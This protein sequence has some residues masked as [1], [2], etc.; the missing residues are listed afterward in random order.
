MYYCVPPAYLFRAPLFLPDG[1]S[2]A[3]FASHW[4]IWG[5]LAIA[6]GGCI[7]KG[8]SSGTRIPLKAGAAM[9][10]ITALWVLV[11]WAVATPRER[12]ADAHASLLRAAETSDPDAVLRYLDDSCTVGQLNKQALRAQ[13]QQWFNTLKIQRNILRYLEIRLNVPMATTY[14]NVLTTTGD[15]QPILTKWQ[16]AWRDDP[17]SGWLITH[18]QLLSVN[19]QSVPPG[20]MIP[21]GP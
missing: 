19:D 8:F 1:I 17:Q 20:S 7:W 18:A 9:L 13:L 10:L 3:L 4:A 14:M 12:L 6:G 16:L 21:T 15:D 2:S 5:I 11:A